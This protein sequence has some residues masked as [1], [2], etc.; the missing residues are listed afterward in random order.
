MLTE[1]ELANRAVDEQTLTETKEDGE[2][3]ET[4]VWPT[5]GMGVE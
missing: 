5:G 3:I 1:M 4:E 2:A